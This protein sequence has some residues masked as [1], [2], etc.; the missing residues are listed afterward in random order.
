M[1]PLSLKVRYCYSIAEKNIP[2]KSLSR[3]PTLFSSFFL[4]SLET[5]FW[6]AMEVTQLKIK[7]TRRPTD[8]CGAAA[9]S[10]LCVS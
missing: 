1:F 2:S 6:T 8:H 3:L 10:E 4:K 9:V 7:S 5:S